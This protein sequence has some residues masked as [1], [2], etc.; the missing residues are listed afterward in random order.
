[1]GF[2]SAFKGLNEH[3][4]EHQKLAMNRVGNCIKSTGI[5]SNKYAKY[6]GAQFLRSRELNQYPCT[7]HTSNDINSSS[8]SI[9]SLPV[10]CHFAKRMHINRPCPYKS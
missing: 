6:L 5:A 2:N 3:F 4:Y 7:K 9:V 8:K 1:M 10:R